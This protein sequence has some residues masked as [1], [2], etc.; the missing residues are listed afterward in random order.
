MGA[1]GNFLRSLTARAVGN[2]VKI[3]DDK[4][5]ETLS[6]R[7]LSHVDILGKRTKH[8]A[9]CS[10]KPGRSLPP[11]GAPHDS[12]T[13]RRTVRRRLTHF[14][15]YSRTRSKVMQHGRYVPLRQGVLCACVVVAIFSGEICRVVW[16]KR[17]VAPRP[18]CTRDEFLGLFSECANYEQPR[19]RFAKAPATHVE[20]TRGWHSYFIP[21]CANVASCFNAFLY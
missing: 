12:A 18:R 1:V 19:N 3:L 9:P 10:T 4:G 20:C 16:N 7:A 11:V 14:A 5:F 13:F 15:P 6:Q 17:S 8:R 2:V 21:A